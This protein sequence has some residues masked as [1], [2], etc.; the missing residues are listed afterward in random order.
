MFQTI[1]KLLKHTALNN[2][3]QHSLPFATFRI[4]HGILKHP[5]I[6]RTCAHFCVL[7]VIRFLSPMVYVVYKEKAITKQSTQY[8]RI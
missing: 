3:T 2:T 1:F 6:W 4:R 7:F 8:T 5:T